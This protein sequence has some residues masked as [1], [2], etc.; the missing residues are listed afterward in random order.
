MMRAPDQP[1]YMEHEKYDSAKSNVI[2]DQEAT[3]TFSALQMA[4]LLM[5]IIN[6]EH[7]PLLWYTHE[8]TVVFCQLRRHHHPQSLW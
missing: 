7:R 8:N 1:K 3:T 4:T 5:N 6:K 2:Y